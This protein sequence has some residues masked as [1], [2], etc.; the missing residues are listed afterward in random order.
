MQ[1]SQICVQKEDKR[2]DSLEADYGQ[3]KAGIEVAP[4][5]AKKEKAES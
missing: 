1:K 4:S 5:H 2:F 3:E